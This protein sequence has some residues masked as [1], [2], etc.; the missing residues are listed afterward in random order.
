MEFDHAQKTPS[1]MDAVD[2]SFSYLDSEYLRY[3][4]SPP[5]FDQSMDLPPSPT[6]SALHN[7]MGLAHN[8]NEVYYPPSSPSSSTTHNSASFSS[9]SQS[10]TPLDSA[11]I[12]PPALLGSSYTLT[13]SEG[14]SSSRRGSG[15]LSPPA[16]NAAA[17]PRALAGR[18]FNPIVRPQRRK[19]ARRGDD[20]DSEEEDDDFLPPANTSSGSPDSRR[21]TIRRQRIES[22]QRRRDEL[23]DG[24][25]RLKD[26]LPSTNQ[27][28]SKVSLLDRATNHVR[29]LEI[30][31]SELEKRLQDAES[32]VKHL[33]HLN[34]V[35]SVRAV[36]QPRGIATY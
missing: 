7:P 4:P 21:E 35:L 19:A 34:E 36:T 32:Q 11:S 24:Y 15:S 30:A 22:E 3:P 2:T 13:T 6:F 27:K 25:A 9:P 17:V 5:S 23:R 14:S 16:H 10:Y 1:Y 33:R 31:K 12:S 18:R 28:S 20:D 29:N 8:L 26:T